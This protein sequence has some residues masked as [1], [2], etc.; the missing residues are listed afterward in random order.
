MFVSVCQTISR[1]VKYIDLDEEIDQSHSIVCP[2]TF[3][4][5][6]CVKCASWISLHEIGKLLTCRQI[7]LFNLNAPSHSSVAMI[8]IKTQEV[9]WTFV[10]SQCQFITNIYYD[11]V[12]LF[13]LCDFSPCCQR[14][15]WI[16]LV[17]FLRGEA[18]SCERISMELSPPEPSVSPHLAPQ[19]QGALGITA[20]TFHHSSRDCPVRCNSEAEGGSGKYFFS[21]LFSINFFL[22]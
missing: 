2:A 17:M 7:P 1:N 15:S 16:K 13:F 21:F 11:L 9:D 5:Y 10:F 8:D 20:V 19:T 18:L 6:P 14:S 12:L 22:S 3:V 4:H